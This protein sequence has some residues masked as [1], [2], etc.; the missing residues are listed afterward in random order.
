MDRWACLTHTH[1]PYQNPCIRL[2]SDELCWV[3][4][5]MD[6]AVGTG[7]A[8]SRDQQF[9]QFQWPNSN[10]WI[11]VN[12]FQQFHWSFSKWL[13]IHQFQQFPLQFANSNSSQRWCRTICGTTWLHIYNRRPDTAGKL[14]FLNDGGLFSCQEASAE[15]LTVLSST[16][17]DGGGSMFNSR[18]MRFVC[19]CLPIFKWS[20][21]QLILISERLD[22]AIRDAECLLYVCS[23]VQSTGC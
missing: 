22:W 1:H 10:S 9:Q 3:D 16:L 5:R 7:E 21:H 17:E 6:C 23:N 13:L 4:H 14:L 2:L 11:S 15:R 20:T 8:R 19:L 12:M 18:T